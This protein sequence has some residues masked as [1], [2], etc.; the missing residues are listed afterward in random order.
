MK[1]YVKDIR[2]CNDY[3]PDGIFINEINKYENAKLKEESYAAWSTLYTILKKE[4]QVSDFN[5]R[6][7][8][9]QK[10]YIKD[11]YFN[12]S[13][14]NKMI[15]IIISN[16]ECGIDIEYINPYKD[17]TNLKKRFH[18]N[19]ND[20]FY[21]QWTRKEAYFKKIG[22]GIKISSL[23]EEAK[24]ISTIKVQDNDGNFY[25]VSYC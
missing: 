14:S 22:T 7:N 1:I 19:N 11:L 6:Y 21:K 12:I 3:I 15:A 10:P 18:I 16:E 17:I 13:H 5:I 23:F 24:E 8:Q 2:D 9:Y 20:E 25:Y 4:Y